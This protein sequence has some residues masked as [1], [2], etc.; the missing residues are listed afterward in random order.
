[1][2]QRMV[3]RGHVAGQDREIDRDPQCGQDC[4][5]HARIRRDAD[6][7]RKERDEEQ[8]VLRIR[9]ADEKAAHDAR[10]AA[11]LRCRLAFPRVI[12]VARPAGAPFAEQRPDGQ[13]RDEHATRHVQPGQ[14]TLADEYDAEHHQHRPRDHHEARGIR[15]D[16]SQ[17]PLAE[18]APR[19]GADHEHDDRAG[20]RDEQHDR[21]E[22]GEQQRVMKCHDKKLLGEWTRVPAAVASSCFSAADCTVF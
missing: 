22:I 13:Y 16:R 14:Q 11:R 5:A 21:G 17:H 6:E 20:R 8:Q 18:A 19:D 12:A 3:D 10:Q 7:L 1:M 2:N 15:A 4:Q 9:D